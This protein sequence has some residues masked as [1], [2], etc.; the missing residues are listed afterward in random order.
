MIESYAKLLNRLANFPDRITA[1]IVGLDDEGVRWRPSPGEFSILE[2]VAHLRDLETE[3]STIRVRRLL[4]EE[5][6][7]LVDFD[8][9]AVAAA[10]RYNDEAFGEAFTAFSLARRRNMVRLFLATDAEFLRPATFGDA[11]VT[12]A[13]ILDRLCAHDEEHGIAI[14]AIASCLREEQVQHE[15]RLTPTERNDHVASQL[16]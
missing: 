9:T 15:S 5:N 12:L 2:N 8:G 14:E 6:P 11:K 7:S 1:T 4:S 13:I 16:F 3:A 10:S